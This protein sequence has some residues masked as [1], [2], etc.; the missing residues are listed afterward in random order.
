MQ[1]R[2]NIPNIITREAAI[3][4]TQ[5][6]YTALM[7]LVKLNN[8]IEQFIDEVPKRLQQIL[9]QLGQQ[10]SLRAI[11]EQLTKVLKEIQAMH[12][13]YRETIEN[14]QKQIGPLAS[15]FSPEINIAVTTSLNGA[16]TNIQ[17]LT[18]LEKTVNLGLTLIDLGLTMYPILEMTPSPDTLIKLANVMKK[19][20]E[21]IPE[22]TELQTHY[23]QSYQLLGALLGQV[24]T[25]AADLA[26]KRENLVNHL[27]KG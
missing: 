27:T 22:V 24:D 11:T 5:P 14:L 25:I 17:T 15:S 8:E 19:H 13:H 7:E 2:P 1:S 21:V 20:Q 26:S 16:Q 3:P 9:S 18:N 12:K 23:P 10:I 4:V 6:G